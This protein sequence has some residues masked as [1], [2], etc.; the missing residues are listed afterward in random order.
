M[1]QRDFFILGSSSECLLAS[2]RLQ[3]WLYVVSH[4]CVGWEGLWLPGSVWSSAAPVAKRMRITPEGQVHWWLVNGVSYQSFVLL[5]T[6]CAEE[7]GK[8]FLYMLHFLE[9]WANIYL[10]PLVG[11]AGWKMLFCTPTLC[12]SAPKHSLAFGVVACS[13][14]SCV[15]FQNRCWYS[16]GMTG[17]SRD[18]RELFPILQYFFQL[19]SLQIAFGHAKGGGIRNP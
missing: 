5:M 16:A 17:L 19:F 6:G 7:T 13:R 8:S 18:S 12:F 9:S 14:C 11:R 15:A 4:L 2:F 1:V 10:R 3:K